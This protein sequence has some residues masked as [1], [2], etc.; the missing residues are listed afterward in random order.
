MGASDAAGAERGREEVFAG[1]EG[2]SPCV[3]FLWLLQHS[4]VGG[5]TCYVQKHMRS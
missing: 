4:V 5:V 2:D 1:A 3:L